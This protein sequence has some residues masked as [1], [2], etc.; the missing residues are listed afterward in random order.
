MSSMA[1]VEVFKIRIENYLEML[2]L[3]FGDASAETAKHATIRAS[4][5]EG[6][7]LSFFCLK[8]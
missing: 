3:T 7:I 5:M 6:D 1:V 8:S 4:I 2:Y